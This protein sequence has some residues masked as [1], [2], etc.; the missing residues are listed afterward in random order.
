MSKRLIGNALLTLA[1]FIWGTAFVAQSM[2]MDYLEPFTFNSIRSVIGGLALLPVI[3]I[4]HRGR[5]PHT[6]AVKR[7][8]WVGGLL[9]GV[10]LF[11][12][13]SFQQI[14][15]Q[16]TTVGKASFIT[17]LYIV[18]VPLVGLFLGKR[19]K[20]MLWVAVALAAAGLFL[21]CFASAGEGF[22]IQMGDLL[23]LCCAFLFTAHILVIDHFSPRVDCVQMACMQFFVAGGLGLVCMVLFEHPELSMILS[24]WAPIL[25]AGLL[26]SGVAYTLQIVGQRN[27]NPTV[28]SLIFSL[29]AVFGSLA[30]W[31]LLGERFT[32]REFAGAA[33]M[34][35]AILLAQLP[36]RK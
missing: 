15:I 21:L 30:G 20:P 12:A 1:A 6:P 29:E 10:V 33:L 32:S 4:M 27:T 31:L 34:F 18:L 26:S 17:T 25:Y 23:I 22:T 9:C 14:G 28:A 8:T 11:F 19:V 2:G 7:N 3:T 35:T 5:A 16:F 36:E 13:S 24:C